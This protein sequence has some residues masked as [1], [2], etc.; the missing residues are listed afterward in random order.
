MKR[1]L[2]SVILVL[3]MVM[4]ILP[5]FATETD[6]TESVVSD[7]IRYIINDTFDDGDLGNWKLGDSFSTLSLNVEDGAMKLSAPSNAWTKVLRANVRN[8][9]SEKLTFKDD[10]RIVVKTRMMQKDTLGNY[11]GAFLKLNRPSNETLSA[12][13]T[14]GN[15]S[16]TE[17]NGRWYTAAHIS[18]TGLAGFNGI[19]RDGSNVVNVLSNTDMSDKWVDVE[20]VFGGK[21]DANGRREA[22]TITLTTTDATGKEV[23][24]TIS[25]TLK[26]RDYAYTAA[27]YDVNAED[28]I[29]F[30]SLD[31]ISF[32]SGESGSTIY[33]DYVQVYEIY[34][35]DAA[36][37]LEN[38]KILNTDDIK[39]VFESENTIPSI[40]EGAVTLKN[41]AGAVV[42]TEQSYDA[43]TKT[44]TINPSAD[45]ELGVP[46]TVC[47]DPS[48]FPELYINYTGETEMSVS[49]Y[50]ENGLIINDTFDNGSLGNWKVG[51]SIYSADVLALE[52]S[53]MTFA[54]TNTRWDTLT[55]GGARFDF[56]ERLEF[57]D[58]TKI[59]IE[60]RIKMGSDGS[61]NYR[62][63]SLRLNRPQ[64]SVLA[65]NSTLASSAEYN[66][67]T[68][69]VLQIKPT[70]LNTYNSAD[71]V[72]VLTGVDMIDKWVDVK[73]VF[74][75]K[76]DAN[77][78][79]E[80]YTISVK[81]EDMEDAAVYES[82]LG[83]AYRSYAY[84][85]AGY[86]TTAADF[87]GFEGI[88][89]I[90]VLTGPSP[91]KFFVDYFKVYEIRAVE[92]TASLENE[93]I[94][95]TDDIKLV[96][97]C[98]NA[99]PSIPEGAVTLKN[100][101]GSVVETE[102][103]YDAD[104]KTLTI[105]PSAD[106]ELG[107]P[108]TVCI[109]PSGF[110]EIMVN[111]TG[112]TNLT[113]FAYGEDGL[114]INDTFDDGSLGNWKL[115]GEAFS[116]L[117]LSVENGAMKLTAPA[118]NWAP[119]LR[120]SVRNDFTEKLTFKDD[121]KIVVKTRMMQKDT[122]GN[123]S[124][125]FLKLNRPSNE[126]LSAA[127]TNGNIS[128][129]EINGR[130]YTAAHISKTGLAGFNGIGRDGSNVV[131]VLSNTDMSDKWVDVEMVFGGKADA[132][133]RR[134]AYTITLT[135]TDATGK[136]VKQT[137][138]STLKDRDYA[139][140]AAGYDVN[141]E[142]FIGFESLDNISFV[143]GES[144]STIYV[145]YFKVYEIDSTIGYATMEAGNTVK[146]DEAIELKFHGVNNDVFTF[147]T[148]SVTV[149]TASGE[150]VE[151]TN[152]YDSQTDVLTVKPIENLTKGE[153]YSVN[154]DAAVLA[155]IGMD[156]LGTT[157]FT[158]TARDDFETDRVIINDD[159]N[160]NTTQG[161][162]AGNSK[163][164][165]EATVTAENGMLHVIAPA[166]AYGIGNQGTVTKL[167][168]DGVELTEGKKLVI[169]T[170]VKKVTEGGSFALD[171]NKPED[172]NNLSGEVSL[173]GN[174]MLFNNTNDNITVP[175]NHRENL[176]K[177]SENPEIY[178]FGNYIWAYS[179]GEKELNEEGDIVNKE[180]IDTVNKWV[181]YTIT[182]T[183]EEINNLHVKA[184]VLDD[185]GNVI[186]TYESDELNDATIKTAFDAGE[187][188]FGKIPGYSNSLDAQDSEKLAV[189]E[190]MFNKWLSA[191]RLTFTT[192]KY[193]TA[194]EFYI[195]Y[196]TVE[197]MDAREV[198]TTASAVLK[199]GGVA[200]DI[201]ASGDTVI[202][203]FTLQGNTGTKFAVI[204]A[205]YVNGILEDT[206][207]ETVT[208]ESSDVFTYTE[209]TGYTIP[210]K[211]E[212]VI[213]AFVWNAL[214]GLKPISAVAKGDNH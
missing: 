69:S 110:P 62:Q 99:I 211:G 113:V 185:E 70:L 182:I 74:G 171:L 172:L 179:I 120:A 188:V 72:N 163:T 8:D 57:K 147:P 67:N 207:I 29:G 24:Q 206:H 132:N 139:Y 195:D 6:A 93:K 106:L 41:K 116:T 36:A 64:N 54:T 16:I 26:D 80:A 123:Y 34:T 44:L 184:D 115:G 3:C 129:T 48:G 169:K 161:W 178:N 175:A 187:R 33:V 183:D 150:T 1:K 140:T 77:G 158:V 94:L 170:K 189:M 121:T 32:V 96:F 51:E 58:D 61:G 92:A 9:F 103:S 124:G 153:Y 145:D 55:Q 166:M 4:Q 173:W 73:M 181:E 109:N 52:D 104:T 46:Y 114:I 39:L 149:K 7:N 101:A 128:I 130:W 112:E 154:I 100:K 137:I 14:N 134:E 111:Y 200:T 165:Y 47:V 201:F 191:D 108:Y 143:S 118:N 176:G 45:L 122:L 151:T 28:F 174:Y 25:S 192:S 204:S 18:K 66:G 194:T 152:T 157:Y 10:S 71:T 42:E 23:K 2:L 21:A 60:T 199:V 107:V 90:S 209:K 177:I 50:G 125:V 180:T 105:N 205:I 19:G 133:G 13:L 212:V 17:I 12:A 164:G 75:G 146:Y 196:I 15:I 168:G 89:S 68:Y 102:Q 43:D 126:T 156:Y 214:E 97:E 49:A 40:P 87:I 65:N 11:S 142:D 197:Q 30:E 56:D 78:R 37:T 160:D 59:V 127:L 148:N 95:N 155:S 86:D 83:Y 119:L 38:E 88:D 5:V 144:G 81:T 138:S 167:L 82:T 35:F 85:A 53:A 91:E 135:T 202:P 131:N 159:F 186:E 136:E 98:E 84:Q 210:S 193:N 27:G 213:K 198:E 203:E 63:V 20:M 162:T 22:Y 117:K 190:N 76:A 31:N 141:A 208:S 79:R